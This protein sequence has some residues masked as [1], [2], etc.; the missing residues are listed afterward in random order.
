MTTKSQVGVFAILY[1]T[2]VV[3]YFMRC[4]YSVWLKAL[5]LEEGFSMGEGGQ[6]ASA[7]ETLCGVSKLFGGVLVDLFDPSLVVAACSL[8][9]GLANLLMF[10][11]AISE[12][13]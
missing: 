7:F 4:N 1:L 10:Q 9:C 12:G 6:F 11:G 3:Y 2:Y 13:A 8:V 5:V